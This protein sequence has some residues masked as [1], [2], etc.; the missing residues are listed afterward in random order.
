MLFSF[1][2]T[3]L[4]KS[5]QKVKQRERFLGR[6]REV[7]RVG[8]IRKIVIPDLVMVLRSFGLIGLKDYLIT[9]N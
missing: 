6:V 4:H 9:K 2:S 5:H 7:R 1:T 3:K 8:K